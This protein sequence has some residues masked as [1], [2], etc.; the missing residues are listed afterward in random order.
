MIW[1]VNKNQIKMEKESSIFEPTAI[2]IFNVY[3]EWA[4][5]KEIEE[6]IAMK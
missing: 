6:K 4:K 5:K 1:F 2:L 3:T